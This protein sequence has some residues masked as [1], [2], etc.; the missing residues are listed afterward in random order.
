MSEAVL[1]LSE[2][3][4]DSTI[5]EGITLVD[6]WAPWC[7]PCQMQ[8]PILDEVAAKVEAKIGKVNTD[9]NQS[10]AAKFGVMSIPTLILFKDGEV[11]KQFVGVQQAEV[12]IKA[13][14]E[15]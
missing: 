15:A 8:I 7:G 6:F 3:D 4:F 13:I 14:E 1:Q 12:L 11:V 2:E 9:E 5:A 10:V